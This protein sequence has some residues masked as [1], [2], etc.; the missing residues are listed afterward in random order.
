MVKFENKYTFLQFTIL[1]IMFSILFFYLVGATSWS[2]L[3]WYMVSIRSRPGG[4]A[5]LCKCV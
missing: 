3:F 5:Y 1:A 2:L 4:R